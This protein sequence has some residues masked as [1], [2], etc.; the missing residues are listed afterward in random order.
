M[1]ENQVLVLE[2]YNRIKTYLEGLWHVILE[3]DYI[4]IRRRFCD[5]HEEYDRAYICG[6]VISNSEG[7]FLQ[8]VEGI[9]FTLDGDLT[10]M[11]NAIDFIFSDNSNKEDIDWMRNYYRIEINDKF[12][13][14]LDKRALEVVKNNTV[15]ETGWKD[16]LEIKYSKKDFDYDCGSDV[17]ALEGTSIFD[18]FFAKLHPKK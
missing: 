15:Y 14:E 6:K 12:L 10:Y 9:E 4:H 2:V 13:D 3:G 5:F 11:P 17:L 18:D 1:T 16:D 8:L 7:N